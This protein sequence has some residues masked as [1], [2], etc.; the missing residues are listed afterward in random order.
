M[1]TLQV[2]D[3]D[4][5]MM[6]MLTSTQRRC[7]VRVFLSA[8]PLPWPAVTRGGPPNHSARNDRL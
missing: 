2:A 7:Y 5:Y 1:S 4:P 8:D 3:D 6:L